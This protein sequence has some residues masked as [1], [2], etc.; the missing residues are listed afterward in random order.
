MSNDLLPQPCMQMGQFINVDTTPD[1]ISNQELR[2]SQPICSQIS[3]R[4]DFH[5]MVPSVVRLGSVNMDTTLVP[6]KRK[7]P[8]QQS[9]QNKRMVLPMEGQPWVSAPMPM[10]LSSVSP[11][12]QYLP[13]SFVSKNSSVSCNKPGKQT[14][15]RKQTSQKPMLLK[16]QSESAGSVRFKMRESL[17][18]ALGMVQCHMEV[19]K[20]SKRLDSETVANL[21]EGHVS[22]P[23]SALS[24]V[25]VM[26][27]NG[28]TEILTLSDPS[29]L[30]GVSVQ[31]V[32]PEILTIT[33]TSDAQEIVAQEPEALKP[34]VQDNVSYSDNVFSKDDL[35]QGNDLSWALESDIDFTV[36]CQNDMIGAM[37]NDGSQE[38]LL[39]DPQVLAFEIEAEL[40]KLF[41]GVN[42]KYKEKG[43]S[44][45]FNLKDKSNPKL[46][47]KVMYGEIAAER[48]CSMSAEE[49]ASKELAEWRQEKAEEMAQMV[50]LQD[51]EVDIRSLVRK[52]HKGE[53][54]VEVEPMDSGSV[55][56]SV[57]MSSLNWSR[58][59]NIKKKTPSITKA[60]GIKNELNGSNEGTGPINGVTIDDEMQTA[61]GSLPTIVSLDEFMSSIDSE[62]PSVSDNNDVEAHL[63]CISPKENANIDLGTS[64]VKAEAFSPLKAEDGDTVSLKPDSDLKS[65][66]ISGFIPDGERL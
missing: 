34:F 60:H 50:V 25:D 48:L 7:S 41:G 57:G 39:L 10:Q 65:E 45:L 32:L 21:L 17:A 46:R 30:V 49:L 37:A 54:Q 26:V 19:P 24:G 63:V 16:S 1:L 40:F 56:V 51:T 36:N 62:S 47:E 53:F 61:T 13:A 6:G 15:A 33:K 31:T 59:K 29:T 28:S 52:T 66:I 44:L 4:Q 64:P 58:P 3:G 14:A 55:E 35:L 22:E 12:T 38:K 5:V 43:R 8:L 42:K 2:L 9:V 27:S 18:G 20:E 11:R 23:V